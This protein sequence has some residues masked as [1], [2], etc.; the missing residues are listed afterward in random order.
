LLSIEGCF[1]LTAFQKLLIHEDVVDDKE[2]DYHLT[3]MMA[4][5]M[6]VTKK[7]TMI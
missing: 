6:K 1:I 7:G 2:E 5:M 3:I 4:M